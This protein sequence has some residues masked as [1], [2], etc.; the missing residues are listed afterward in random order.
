LDNALVSF[1]IHYNRE[2]KWQSDAHFTAAIADLLHLP[3]TG[4]T[5]DFI[6]FKLNCD[7]FFVRTGRASSGG[8]LNIE[9]GGFRDEVARRQAVIEQKKRVGFKP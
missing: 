7:G 8:T 3:V 4:W 9:A 1:T 6:F 2:V 5:Y